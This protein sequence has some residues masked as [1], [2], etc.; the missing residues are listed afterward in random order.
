MAAEQSSDAQQLANK[1]NGIAVSDSDAENAQSNG[2]T[3]GVTNGE[4]N[5]HGDV[6]KQFVAENEQSLPPTN[7]F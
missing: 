1:L 7:G 3:E 4:L 5:G 6:I 2:S